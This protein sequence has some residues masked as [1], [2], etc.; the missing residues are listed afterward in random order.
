MV[1][2]TC[3]KKE[4]SFKHQ[5]GFNQ[6]LHAI[7]SCKKNSQETQQVVCFENLTSQPD[8]PQVW[9]SYLLASIKIDEQ[10]PFEAIQLI[11][12]GLP[13]TE[14][15]HLLFERAKLLELRSSVHF[16]HNNRQQGA[17]DLYEAIDI[18]VSLGNHR[19][20]G[21]SLVG[22]AN[23]QFNSENYD[24]A[25][26]N[27]EQ[28]IKHYLAARN[29]TRNDSAYMMNCYNTLGLANFKLHNL[30]SAA[31]NYRQSLA[32][33]TALNEEFWKALINGNA[34]HID[35]QEGRI[36]TA[37]QKLNTDIRI[38]LKFKEIRSAAASYLSVGEIYMKANNFVLTKIYY[39]SALQLYTTHH[40]PGVDPRY[41]KLMAEWH[42][43]NNNMS[44]A[45]L[46]LKRYLSSRDSVAEHKNSLLL[47]QLQT[48]R[49]FQKQ[50]A[51]INLLAAN[52][53][54]KEEELRI[55]EISIIAFLLILLLLLL[56]VFN[57]RRS[58]AAL[59]NV[60]N[61]LEAKVKQ[62][63]ASILKLNKELDTYLYRASH[64][65]RGPILSIQGLVHLFNFTNSAE[66]TRDLVMKIDSTA[67]GMD[68][69]LLKLQMAYELNIRQEF[70][71]V[72]LYDLLA[73]TITPLKERYPTTEFTI[74]C[75][76]ET[77][78]YTNLYHL[79]VA[80]SNII[81]NACIFRNP[82]FYINKVQIS[83]SQTNDSI[84]ILIEDNGIGIPYDFFEKIFEA[85]QRL[86]SLSTGNGMGLYLSNKAINSIHGTI[87]V[88][89]QI[90]KGSTFTIILPSKLQ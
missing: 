47:Q 1:A 85:F 38:S 31:N 42:D 87:K 77:K 60:N 19:E 69:M 14:N 54:L 84:E 11:N 17:N 37:I 46:Y 27:A 72:N 59:R 13:L 26:E 4:D 49:V 80:L 50:L 40:I 75:N 22:I 24:L 8:I 89:S 62:R 64:D 36:E 41:N 45:Y 33:A 63:M 23:L 55:R 16:N 57:I 65:I 44:K 83:V 73:S 86:S 6:F 7:D 70:E 78:I 81:E 52:N 88:S 61:S 71:E 35:E 53:K 67:K 34:A 20:A 66:E 32:L 56:L 51:D 43:A 79:S 82:A 76:H 29:L 48:K 68:S 28:A 18:Y 74:H 90:N 2:A 12:D 5:Q 39:D 58:N 30:K 21:H 3:G 25:R 9:K 15:Q 10:K